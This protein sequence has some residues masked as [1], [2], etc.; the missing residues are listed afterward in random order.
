[1]VQKVDR[2]VARAVEVDR[3]QA[4][5]E[6]VRRGSLCFALLFFARRRV[7]ARVSVAQKRAGVQKPAEN[8]LR[9]VQL[10]AKPEATS[11]GPKP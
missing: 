10:F 3:Q 4:E 11:L 6:L 9:R 2:P 7:L 1:M 8:G 5:K